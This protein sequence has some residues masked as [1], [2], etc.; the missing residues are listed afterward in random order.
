ME[1]AQERGQHEKK[2]KRI[3]DDLCCVT[4]ENE[5]EWTVDA[6]NCG[7][8]SERFIKDENIASGSW[9][10]VESVVEV[11]SWCRSRGAEPEDSEPPPVNARIDGGGWFHGSAESVIATPPDVGRLLGESA[12]EDCAH[13]MGACTG[14]RVLVVVIERT[15]APDFRV[16][17][18]RLT[19]S[20]W[21]HP[22]VV[23]GEQSLLFVAESAVFQRLLLDC[24]RAAHF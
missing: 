18:K 21:Q 12:R 8:A 20:I 1:K 7:V 13:R 14:I 19:L 15:L 3:E 2:E 22:I 17:K 16:T 23:E 4:F 24:L 9:I 10:H 5:D 6:G 11:D